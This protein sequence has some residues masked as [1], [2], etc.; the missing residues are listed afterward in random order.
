[1]VL[2]LAARR[3]NLAALIQDCYGGCSATVLAALQYPWVLFTGWGL[4]WLETTARVRGAREAG[5]R[6]LPMAGK[7]EEISF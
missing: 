2:M 3:R 6:A 7:R 5:C 1:V 4:R